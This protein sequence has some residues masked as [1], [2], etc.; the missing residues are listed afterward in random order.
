MKIVEKDFAEEL[1]ARYMSKY[2]DT[3]SDAYKERIAKLY[4]MSD[5]ICYIGYMW[6]CFKNY[7]ITDEKKCL[8]FLTQKNEYMVLWDINSRDYIKICDYWKYSK[9]TVISLRSNELAEV[10]STLPEDIYFFDET[11]TWTV[12]LTHE[13]TEKGKRSCILLDK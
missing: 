13:T 2:I 10:L 1:R 11:F 3:S 12:V 6:D 8:E 9:D 4:K 5:G 7:I